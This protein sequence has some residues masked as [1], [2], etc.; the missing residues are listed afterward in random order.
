MPKIFI[1]S[2]WI[3]FLFS[4]LCTTA[5][6]TFDEQSKSADSI[7]CMRLINIA[8]DSLKEY[9]FSVR[10]YLDSAKT[11]AEKI[12]SNFLKARIYIIEGH[13]SYLISDSKNAFEYLFRADSLI[14]KEDRQLFRAYN[15]LEISSTYMD[16]ALYDKAI[17]Y[18]DNA[19]D[20]YKTLNEN[21]K[22]LE[23]QVTYAVILSE[24]GKPDEALSI[25][26]DCEKQ[27][28]DSTLNFRIIDDISTTLQRLKRYDEAL[29]Y[30]LKLRE[31]VQK[32]KIDFLMAGYSLKISYIYMIKNDY[33]SALEYLTEAKELSE[34][35][36]NL[37]IT[38]FTNYS[39]F[40]YYSAQGNSKKAL[41]Y[42]IEYIRLKDEIAE[43]QQKKDIVIIEA[44]NK[45]REEI[46]LIELR[47]QMNTS[48]NELQIKYLIVIAAIFMLSF[49]IS[50]TLF[51]SRKNA[52]RKLIEK[53]KEVI[54]KDD[55]ISEITHKFSK[56]NNLEENTENETDAKSDKDPVIDKAEAELYNK[57]IDLFENKKVYTDIELSQI[58]LSEIMKEHTYKISA[59]VNKFTNNNFSELLNYYRI[60]DAQKMLADPSF[61]KYSIGGISLMAGYKHVSTFHAVFKKNTG[62]TPSYYRKNS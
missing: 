29:V 5:Q 6:V 19:R 57:I 52:F 14:A 22:L 25:L 46:K 39:L 13:I 49:L 30:F 45:Y 1:I 34:K 8:G 4:T 26:Q 16:L 38:L 47:N 42:H 56:N 40:E 23:L 48:K 7:D 18:L 32:K 27:N 53:N 51:L 2:I 3:V 36:N 54:S 60:K 62:L 15:Y 41:E 61:D 37:Q 24:K 21:Q 33:K 50:T 55:E 17:L 44:Q 35:S 9:N 31:T 10:P 59:V 20:I 58:K 28:T 43:D 12:N 11:I